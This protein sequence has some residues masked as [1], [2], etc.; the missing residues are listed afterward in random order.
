MKDGRSKTLGKIT[1]LLPT[2]YVVRGKVMFWHVSVHPSVCPQGGGVR[3]LAW[4]EH[5]QVQ[6]GG[7][8][9]SQ[10]WWGECTP[11]M[12]SGGGGGGTPARS[13][14]GTPARSDG[15][16]TS[17]VQQGVPHLV[18]TTPATT[19]RGYPG[20]VW[21]GVPQPGPRWGVPPQPGMASPP[22]RV[23]PPPGTGQQMQYLIRRGRYASC[24]HAGGLSCICIHLT[25]N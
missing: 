1:Y 16:Y 3:H 14:G 5:D 17:Q 7:G 20:Q 10:V 2:A 15:G 8:Y 19:A 13:E 11:A 24:V 25:Q 23:L 21:W 6:T 9:P 12:S 18:G 4:G 22:A